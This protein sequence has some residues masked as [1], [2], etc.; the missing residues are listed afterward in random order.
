MRLLQRRLPPEAAS[1]ICGC[2][3]TPHR[4]NITA[5][6]VLRCSKWSSSRFVCSDLAQAYVQI[7]PRKLH[8]ACADSR[9]RDPVTF[10]Q[11]QEHS[12]PLSCSTSASRIL[13][14][15]K[16]M[17]PSPTRS[18]AMPARPVWRSPKIFGSGTV[19]VHLLGV[20]HSNE[21]AGS[22]GPSTSTGPMD[23]NRALFW[24]EGLRH[25]S[26]LTWSGRWRLWGRDQC[27]DPRSERERRARPQLGYMGRWVSRR[28]VCYFCIP[29][30]PAVAAYADKAT[31]LLT[32]SRTCRGPGEVTARVDRLIQEIRD[33]WH[34]PVIG[35]P[36]SEVQCGD[37]L[38]V[39][40]GHILRAFAM[41]WARKTLQD[42]PAFL[43][44]AGGIGTLA[45]VPFRALLWVHLTDNRP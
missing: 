40:H 3:V 18:K 2:C 36:K 12:V 6:H 24:L 43:L 32:S 35:K 33:K 29:S 42:G 26:L 39:A 27:P 31:C 8:E 15:G 13:C 41:R 25:D 45:W 22:S 19:S 16:L 28:R 7:L 11:E 10:L 23:R 20:G 9:W 44:E 34:A 30:L 1:L 5:V 4:R 17:A 38:I 21:S 37:V 14:R